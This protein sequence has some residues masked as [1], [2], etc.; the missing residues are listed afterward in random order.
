MKCAELEWTRLTALLL[1]AQS[2]VAMV[3]PNMTSELDVMMAKFLEERE[4]RLATEAH[5]KATGSLDSTKSN[6]TD[7][8]VPPRTSRRAKRSITDIDRQLILDLH[9]KLRSQVSP[10]AADMEYMVSVHHRFQNCLTLTRK[11]AVSHVVFY[12]QG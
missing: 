4:K 1:V 5:F 7:P 2:V 3:R 12:G 11:S 9:N 8:N 10:S 6:Y